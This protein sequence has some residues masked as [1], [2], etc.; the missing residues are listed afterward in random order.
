M[1]KW[2]YRVATFSSWTGKLKEEHVAEIAQLGEEGW[3][4]GGMTAVSTILT[5]IFKR[6]VPSAAHRERKGWPEW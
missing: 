6:P 4:L 5:L 1:T 2:E 3:E